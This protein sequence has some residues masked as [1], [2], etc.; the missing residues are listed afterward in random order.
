VPASLPGT[1]LCDGPLSCCV[2]RRIVL[3]VAQ[4]RTLICMHPCYPQSDGGGGYDVIHAS[5]EGLKATIIATSQPATAK[6]F[7]Q[8]IL[9]VLLNPTFYDCKLAR[10]T[11]CILLFLLYSLYISMKQVGVAYFFK[12]NL[13][14]HRLFGQLLL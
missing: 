6:L 10:A 2:L 11:T 1:C 9:W 7:M 4:L 12:E 14:N 5:N 13:T 3:K 8:G